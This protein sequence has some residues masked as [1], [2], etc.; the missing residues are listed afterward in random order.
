MYTYPT[1][2]FHKL[3]TLFSINLVYKGF[4]WY[5]F[6]FQSQ[7]YEIQDDESNTAAAKILYLDT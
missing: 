3:V 4:Q 5:S 6:E 2:I 7:E 1:L